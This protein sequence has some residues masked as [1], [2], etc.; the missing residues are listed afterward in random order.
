MTLLAG[1]GYGPECLS[2]WVVTSLFGSP[3]L[4]EGLG[5]VR[6]TV[7]AEEATTSPAAP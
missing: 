5:L 2:L 7:V 6:L 4:P 3:P 1:S